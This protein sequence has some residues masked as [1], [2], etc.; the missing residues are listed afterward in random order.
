VDFT[1]EYRPSPDELTR[2][3][4]RGYRR[5]RRMLT[6]GLP[7][8][9]LAG[10]AVCALVG[11][12]AYSVGL[13][14]GAIVA[15]F[16]SEWA[17]RRL[18]RRIAGLLCVPA[19]VRVTGDGYEIRTELSTTWVRW[20]MFGRVESTPEFWLLYGNRLFAA[21]LPRAAFDEAQQAEIDNILASRSVAG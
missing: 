13:V 16:A 19:T 11:A 12:V 8:V 1:V 14:A 5:Q 3:F 9:C 6:W 21:F 15:P 10:A 18:F 20:A 4:R 2:A 7:A 17:Y